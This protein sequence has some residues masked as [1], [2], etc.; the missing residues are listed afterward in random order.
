[1][2]LVHV[3]GRAGAHRNAPGTGRARDVLVAVDSGSRGVTLR[4]GP[5]MSGLIRVAHDPATAAPALV[6]EDVVTVR[7]RRGV[8]QGELELNPAYPWRFKVHGPTWNTVLD[9]PGLDVRE[10]RL[11]GG[12][13]RVDCALPPPR[14]AVPITVAGG[15]VGVTLRRSPGVKV[16]AE[17]SAGALQL[18]LDDLTVGAAT[19]DLRWESAGPASDDHYVLRLSGGAARVTLSEDPAVL[20]PAA[21]VDAPAD[22]DLTA[23]DVLLDGVAAQTTTHH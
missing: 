1:M 2:M 17:V 5:T 14:G 16:L 22:S 10:I 8:G 6:Q 12:A 18:R 13:A 21:A 3:L 20:A 9:L 23:L 19:A 7:R 15:V 4:P 11:D